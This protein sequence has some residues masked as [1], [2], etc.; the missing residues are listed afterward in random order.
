MQVH[1][2]LLA[3]VC[4][5]L[6]SY[7][8]LLYGA[9]ELA[10]AADVLTQHNDNL[11]TGANT[12]ETLLT[13]KNVNADSFGKLWTLY[14]DG[15]I[16][17]QPLYVE[18][19]AVDTSSNPN[20]PLVKGTFNTVIVATMHNT[21]YAYKA[22]EENPGEEGRTKPLWAT[23]LG[24]A[25][26][27]NKDK[28][29]MWSTNDPEWGVLGTPVIDAEKKTL[30][31][32]AWHNDAGVYRYRLH[33]LDVQSG[34]PTKPAVIIGG[35]PLNAQNP[36]EYAK[37]FNACNQKQRPALLLSDG[38]IYVAFG[39]DGNPGTV[40]AFDAKTLAER[41]VWAS[42]TLPG[43]S[44]GIWQSGLGP[45]A[46]ADGNVYLITGN[47]TFDAD[48][49]GPNFGDSLVRL[50]LEG[51][52]LSVKDYFTP[53]DQ[54]FLN[55]IDLD[56]G[57]G[58]AVL[59]PGTKLTF[60]GGKSGIVY[61]LSRDNLG[62]YTAGPGG[63]GCKNPNALQEFQATDIHVHGAG[64]TY[65]HIHSS[66][67][68]WKG[69]DKSR[70]YVWGENDR[71]KAFVFNGTKFTGIDN[72]VR[73]I[74]QPPNGM[75][76]GMLSLSSN[77]QKA[78]TGIIWAVVPRDGD[79]NLLRGVQG[80]LMALDAQDIS[81]QLWTSDVAGVRDRLGLFAKYV[82]PTI[83]G[84]KVFVATYGDQ[85]PLRQY[86][87]DRPTQ[88]PNY[89]VAVYGALPPAHD[90][91]KPIINQAGDDVAV[92][93]A[94]ATAAF[95]LDTQ[96]CAADKAGNVDCTLALAAKAGAP[97]F[98]TLIVPIGYNFA[99]CNLLTVTTASKQ[100]GLT[101]STGIGWYAADALAGNQ[102]MTSGRF[103][104]TGSLKQVGSG[105][106]VSGAP[107]LLHQFVGLANCTVGQGSFDKLFKPYMQFDNSPEDKIFRNWDK[108]ENYRISR[109]VPQFDRT[110]D[111]LQP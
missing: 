50:K 27:G 96:G 42:T 90:H 30:W 106:L 80:V 10:H 44:G 57:A 32:V 11:R 55:G 28:I 68:F 6:L 16:V 92:I 54:D 74:Y 97:A 89:Y 21:I 43:K 41:G 9:L 105:T 72:P 51:S 8:A 53:C 58:G 40:F 65:G 64:T 33:A 2:R 107:A 62:H 38:V 4:G 17:A 14:V 13:T 35:E 47:G 111:V 60:G 46:D 103:V 98:H 69:P 18:K 99:G 85:E 73:S 71:M 88:F 66:P 93:K 75:P 86:A 109:T 36:C 84:G 102:A 70:I 63:S 20:T 101:A 22:D 25:R 79:A 56:F 45:S 24:K 15:Q 83:A 91:A 31:A 1:T 76:G 110:G 7:T 59:I 78:G 77:G 48:R 82:P 23:W 49:G 29:D 37:G 95:S 5:A 104:P 108:A 12:A 26:P 19:L 39:G 100:T 61:L 67:V 52:T 94:V 3:G 87:N 81:K 34:A